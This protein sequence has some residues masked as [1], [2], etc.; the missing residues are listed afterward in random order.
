MSAERQEQTKKPHPLQCRLP[1]PKGGTDQE[2]DHAPAQ[3]LEASM[4]IAQGEHA[5]GANNGKCVH[6]GWLKTV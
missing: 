4:V 6:G 5:L 1:D 3:G 2:Q